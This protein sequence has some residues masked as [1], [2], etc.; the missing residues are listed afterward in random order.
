[1]KADLKKL[2]SNKEYFTLIS[3]VIALF[4]FCFRLNELDHFAS[5]RKTI[6]KSDGTALET[7]PPLQKVNRIL[8]SGFINV[9][10][11]SVVSTAS[12]GTHSNKTR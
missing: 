4:I 1:M 3:T 2:R 7:K 10:L 8:I 11:M 9:P 12:Y 5:T 6:V